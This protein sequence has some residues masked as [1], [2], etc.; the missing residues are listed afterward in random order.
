MIMFDKKTSKIK[1]TSS[2]AFR[3]KHIT[4]TYRHNLTIL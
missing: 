4:H 1:S 3:T 2:E